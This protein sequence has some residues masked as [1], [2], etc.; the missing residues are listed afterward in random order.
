MAQPHKG[1]TPFVLVTDKKGNQFICLMD[2]LKDPK[3]ASPDELKNCV[4]EAKMGVNI[5][6]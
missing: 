5:G 3:K 1:S 6:D 2:A 4:D